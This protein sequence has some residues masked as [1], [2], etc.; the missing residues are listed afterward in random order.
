[1]NYF[2]KARVLPLTGKEI[3]VNTGTPAAEVQI[4]ESLV[5]ALLQT[6]HPELAALDITP[7]DSGWD[8][9]VFRLGPKL[10][11]RIPRRTA[12]ADLVRHEQT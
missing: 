4:D 8:N 11:V 7:V 10:A 1:V 9:A 5:R 12:A 3:A 2:E 6:Q